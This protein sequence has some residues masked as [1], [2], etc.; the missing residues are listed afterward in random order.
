MLGEC[1][2]NEEGPVVT[3]LSGYVLEMLWEGSEFALYRG[4]RP[5]NGVPVLLRA[6][7]STQQTSANLRWL[8]HAYS[9]ANELD[10]AWAVRPLALTHHHRRTALLLEDPGGEPLARMVARPLALTR[11]LHIAISLTAALR[12]VHEHGLVHKTSIHR[13]CWS[14]LPTTCG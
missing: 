13:M 14:T 5:G 10:P 4:R 2:T 8:E 12:Q 11:F 3:E 9:L 7:V 1:S 6:P